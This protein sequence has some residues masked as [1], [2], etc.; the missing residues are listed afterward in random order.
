[1][2]PFRAAWRAYTFRSMRTAVALLAL[3]TFACASTPPRRAAEKEV[4]DAAQRIFDVMEAGDAQMLASLLHPDARLVAVIDGEAKIRTGAEWVAGIAGS[5]EPV[6]ERMWDPHVNVAGA[7]AS[8]WAPYD[9]H[10]GERFSHCGTNAMHFVRS[11]G[12]TWRLLSVTFTVQ[13]EG[14]GP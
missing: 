12:G 8:V 6:R 3:L 14:C 11:G 5:R 9:L 13:K 7:V 10:V 1:M 2:D 4:L